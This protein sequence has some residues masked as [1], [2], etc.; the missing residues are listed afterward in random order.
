MNRYILMLLLLILPVTCPAQRT[1]PD[2][3]KL[4]F[5]GGECVFMMMVSDSYIGWTG[6][7]MDTEWRFTVDAW[8]MEKMRLSGRATLHVGIFQHSDRWVIK[9][10][11]YVI[12]DG[13]ARGKAKDMS[14]HDKR[15]GK[16]TVTWQPSQPQLYGRVIR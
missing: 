7:K 16:V 1:P 12:T 9:A 11:P 10:S 6:P 8:T 2:N 14:G 4:C 15:A 3:L 13:I 5:S